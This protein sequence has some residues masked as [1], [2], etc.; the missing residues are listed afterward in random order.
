[1]SIVALVVINP[2]G[3]DTAVISFASTSVG[4]LEKST[5]KVSL[6]GATVAFDLIFK[7]LENA[8]KPIDKPTT[9][10]TNASIAINCT[11]LFFSIMTSSLLYI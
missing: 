6:S 7:V 8:A 5:F 4:E 10:T 9:P 11:V 2:T 3:L 1:M